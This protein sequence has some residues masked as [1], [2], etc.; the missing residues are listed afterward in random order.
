[1]YPIARLDALAPPGLGSRGVDARRPPSR[2]LEALIRAGARRGE[3]PPTA[4]LIARLG[5]ARRRRRFT[6]GEFLAACRWKSPRAA[7]RYA[8]NS[9]GRIARVS[10]AALATRSERRRLALLT[11]LEGVS[12]P[13]ASALLTL[14]DPR[15]YGVLDIRAWQMLFRMGEVT[16]NRRG[17]GF[18]P[19]Q[20]L[21]YLARLRRLARRLGLTARAVE[22]ALFRAHRRVQRGRLYD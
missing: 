5:A 14:T 3:D 10:R 20:W 19:A 11:G 15:R 16:A 8:S 13:T 9:P 17:R 21:E 1:M 7:R 12:V 22:L 4:A 6:R 18:T 2:A